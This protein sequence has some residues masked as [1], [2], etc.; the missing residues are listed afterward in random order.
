MAS[1]PDEVRRLRNEWPSPRPRVPRLNQLMIAV[2]LVVASAALFLIW[3]HRRPP[4]LE[5]FGRLFSHRTWQILQAVSFLSFF[6]TIAIART[7]RRDR[8]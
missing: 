6:A 7:K 4:A 8:T 5:A 1:V 2:S 3:G